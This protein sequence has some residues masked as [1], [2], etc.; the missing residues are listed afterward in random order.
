MNLFNDPMAAAFIPLVVLLVAGWAMYFILARDDS[1]HD[2]WVRVLQGLRLVPK[3][4]EAETPVGTKMNVLYIDAPDPNAP[5]QP[6]PLDYGPAI[7]RSRLFF[8]SL[9]LAML[10]LTCVHSFRF[11]RRSDPY[12][13][14]GPSP[15]KFVGPGDR[16]ELPPPVPGAGGA[17]AAP[18]ARGSGQPVPPGPAPPVR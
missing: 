10:V 17:G 13:L 15:K 1:A 16:G 11:Y 12:F 9:G 5:I 18:F 3:E 4:P 8:K 14:W 6:E 7:E 2:W